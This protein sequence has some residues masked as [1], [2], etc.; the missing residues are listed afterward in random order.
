AAIDHAIS[1]VHNRKTSM[2]RV[3]I[4]GV[5]LSAAFGAALALGAESA[6]AASPAERGDYL[7]N[8]ILA[9]GNCHTPRDAAGKAIADRAF[10]GNGL[11]LATPAFIVTAPNITPDID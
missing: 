6:Q 9:C 10:S 8:T 11:T 4:A 1:R 5:L 7:A 2:F 3:G